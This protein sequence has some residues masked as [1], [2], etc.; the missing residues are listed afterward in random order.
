MSRVSGWIAHAFEQRRDNRIIRPQSEY[1]G[2]R[3]RK[4]TPVSQRQA[5][6]VSGAAQGGPVGDPK[7]KSASY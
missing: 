2:P 7:F 1:V 5:T 4:W 3:D 6:V